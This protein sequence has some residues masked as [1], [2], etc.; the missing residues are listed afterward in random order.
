MQ[1]A[2]DPDEPLSGLLVV[3]PRLIP[4]SRRAEHRCQV[5]QRRVEKIVRS[6]GLQAEIAGFAS[7][8]L[9]TSKIADGAAG[10]DQV[11]GGAERLHVIDA[12]VVAVS[13][14]YVLAFLKSVPVV[15][16]LTQRGCEPLARVEPMRVLLAAYRLERAS[17]LARHVQRFL[18]KPKA[19]QVT[20]HRAIRLEGYQ[21]VVT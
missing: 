21:V 7:Q 12:K 6:T 2:V 10:V 1:L 8:L 11:G 3:R 20:S 14:E 17:D 16:R 15:T 18:I 5:H 19:A 13:L 4:P 9:R